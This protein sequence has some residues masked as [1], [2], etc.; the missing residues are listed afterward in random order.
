MRS[1]KPLAASLIKLL[2][3]VPG[4]RV[5]NLTSGSGTLL[6]EGRLLHK[7]TTFV[8]VEIN[9]EAIMM[10]RRNLKGAALGG[11]VL[12]IQ[13]D[14]TSIP[15]A[16]AS[17][18]CLVSDLPWGEAIGARATNRAL[19]SEILL[20]SA[21]VIANQGRALFLTQDDKSFKEALNERSADWA[22]V[23]QRK[24]GQRGFHPTIFRLTRRAV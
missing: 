22:L 24:V 12:Q 8:G 17:F 18:H 6:I 16:S 14:A 3:L 1:G 11:V 23:E 15:A 19:Y 5:I 7:K 13:G 2:E 10:A 9:R 4:E 20:E 21:R